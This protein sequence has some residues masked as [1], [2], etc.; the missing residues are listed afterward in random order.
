MGPL[1]L[2]PRAFVQIRPPSPRPGIWK[3][4]AL[5][6]GVVALA[7]MLMAAAIV[8]GLLDHP[9]LS[10]AL[11]PAAG[12][13][14]YQIVTIIEQGTRQVYPYAIVPGGAETLDQA[15]RALADPLA[16]AGCPGIDFSK[17]RKVTLR[18]SLSGYISY[19]VGEQ[20]YWTS[21]LVTLH[22]G[23]TVF[24]DD[25][26]LIRGRGLNCYSPLPMMP[27]REDEPDE[28]VLDTPI[29]LPVIAYSFARFPIDPPHLPPR[30]EDLTPS[31]PFFP[32]AVQPAQA[33]LI[34]PIRSHFPPAPAVQLVHDPQ[35]R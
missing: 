9:R 29:Q 17:F 20:I 34:P 35:S 21:N 1:N 12:P 22:V 30:I 33:P 4:A 28:R 24:T 26:H 15:R 8:T 5:I 25:V 14:P 7:S 16:R 2:V 31:F 13:V 32:A 6:V 18:R 11:P 27:T 10:S 23:E 19:R 3:L